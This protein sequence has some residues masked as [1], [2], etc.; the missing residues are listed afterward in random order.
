MHPT[1]VDLGRFSIHSYGFML[2]TSFMV[3]IFV[4]SRRARKFGLDPQ[5]ILD[6]SVYIILS[7]VVGSRL[8]YIVF[9]LEDYRNILDV[10]ALW[11]GG[12]TLYGGL[13]LAVMVS[14]IFT[15]RRGVSFLL[16]ADVISP[17]M[18]L[19][20]V[21]TRVGCFLSGC[22]FGKPTTMPWGVI[23]P[24]GSAGGIYARSFASGPVAIHPTQI[25][26]S[27]GGLIMFILLM[28]MGNKLDRKGSTFGAFLLLYGIHRTVI[29][30]FRHYEAN[31]IIHSMTVNQIVSI[32]LFSLGCFLVLRRG[33]K[34]PEVS[35]GEA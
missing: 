10:F 28:L 2:A 9:H 32:M 15:Y 17:A 12:A 35:I 16:A 6:L 24:P 14:F 31:M 26:S 19:G 13:I 34:K 18:A 20:L 22:C 7:A 29:D 8:A 27:V 25:Y 5:L 3:G 33:D 30:F 23:F 11:Q 4:A 1:L 21:F